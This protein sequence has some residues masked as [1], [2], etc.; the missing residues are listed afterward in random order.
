MRRLTDLLQHS[1]QALSVPAEAPSIKISNITCDSRQVVSGSLFV[2]LKGEKMDGVDFIPQ[3]KRDGA[4]AVLC[5]QNARVDAP[6]PLIRAIE[7]RLALAQIAAA[8]Y[9]H[10]PAHMVAVTGTDGKTST[11]D[12]FR[13]FWHGMREHTRGAFRQ[14]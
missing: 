4:V 13:Q 5:A 12:F 11:A 14:R 7:P 2:A 6:I 3:A 1:A 10:Q 8:F 9:E